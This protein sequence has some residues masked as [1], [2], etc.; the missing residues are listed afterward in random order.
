MKDNND[1]LDHSRKRLDS[2]DAQI[3]DLLQERNQIVKNVIK[4]KIR[5]KLPIFVA[6]REE[7]KVKRFRNQADEHGLDPEW[8]EDFL[9]MIMSSSRAS[10]S[11]G[12][13]PCATDEP[14][15]V[16]IVGGEGG[17]GALYH[18]IFEMSNHNVRILE[19][20]G[21]DKVEDLTRG[22]D[23]AIISVPINV[24]KKVI[25][26]LAPHLYI[27]TILADFTSNKNGLLELMLEKHRGPVV[28]LHPM[29]GPGAPN[30]SKQLMLIC[31]GRE[32]KKYAW[33]L[34]QIELWGMRTKIVDP[35]KHDHAMHLIQGLRHFIALLHGSFMLKYDLRPEDILDFSSP[36]YRAELMM[37]GRI[38]AQHA[39]LYADIVLSN[40][41]RRDLLMDFFRHHQEL[42]K[43]VEND[44]KEGFIR[45]F[46]EV[47]EFFGDFAPQALRESSY[48]INRLADRFA[49]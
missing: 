34:R 22:C 4:T 29:H 10:Q 26:D 2:I 14:K 48:L 36:I 15:N 12:N 24:T 37:T 1:T 44:D 39:D 25:T 19:K 49:D 28:S 8:A 11:K 20:D 7:E 27:N 23:L 45:E 38:F 5:N 6:D 41:E 21:W 46:E 3:L 30:L 17:M 18:K 47:T 9:R 32:E 35:Q 16:L 40:E 13:F 31:P 43:L 42:S 33:L